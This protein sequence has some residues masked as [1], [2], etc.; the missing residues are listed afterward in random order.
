MSFTLSV[1]PSRSVS[2]GGTTLQRCGEAL[3][4]KLL[5]HSPKRRGAHLQGLADMFIRPARSDLAG[6]GGCRKM[7]ACSSLR[8]AAFPRE[9]L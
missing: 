4:D 2:T 1:D 8:A 9:I 6:I 5:A 7:R 3:L